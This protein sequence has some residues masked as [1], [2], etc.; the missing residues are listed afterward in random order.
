MSTFDITF[1]FL[2][3]SI[4]YGGL[5][6]QGTINLLPQFNVSFGKL[7]WLGVGKESDEMKMSL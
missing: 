3:V 2:T 7:A 4:S 1:T 6:L 5:I